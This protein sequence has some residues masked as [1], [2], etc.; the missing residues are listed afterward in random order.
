[1]QERLNVAELACS[2]SLVHVVHGVLDGGHRVADG[3]Q[4]IVDAD[5]LFDR[6]DVDHRYLR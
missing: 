4:R 1:L 6:L 2:Q 3:L 5:V